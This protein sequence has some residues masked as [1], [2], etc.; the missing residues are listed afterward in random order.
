[1]TRIHKLE[2]TVILALLLFAGVLAAGWVRDRHRMA[3]AEAVAHE[4]GQQIAQREQDIEAR[5]HKAADYDKLLRGEADILKTA[6]QATKVITRYLAAT[7]PAG[8]PASL[9]LSLSPVTVEPAQLSATLQAELPPSPTY[10]VFTEGQTVQLA[11]D[12]LACDATRHTLAACTADKADLDRSLVD[13][14]AI[15]AS[16]EAAAKGGSRWARIRHAAKLAA[17]AAAGAGVA[18]QIKLSPSSTAAA[19]A[20]AVGLCSLF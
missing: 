15:S 3:V 18:S 6:P 16:W 13:E 1:M 8:T 5:D 2:A 17:C 12:E 11:K 19:G 7:A 20:G 9:S 4:R 14:R 10:T